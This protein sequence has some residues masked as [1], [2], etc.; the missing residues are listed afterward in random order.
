MQ[1]NIS[2]RKNW[3]FTLVGICT[4]FV[5]GCKPV[6]TTTNVNLGKE[7]YPILTGRTIEYFVD[8]TIYDDFTGTQISK[9]SYI[10]DVID[11]SFQDLTNNTVFYVKRYYKADTAKN[12]IF[13]QLYTVSALNSKIEVVQDNLRYIKL[14]F[15][16]TY[17]GTWGGNKYIN[18]NST[19]EV[20]SW[21]GDKPY[22]YRDLGKPYVD[23]ITVPMALS[24]FQVNELNGDTNRNNKQSFGE[25]TYGKE[26]YG[27]EI[28]LVFKEIANIKKD[29]A[30]GGKLKGFWTVM[31]C[32][33]WE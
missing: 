3:F 15:P 25:F 20:Y 16:V 9:K 32:V 18:T 10:K 12:Y 17:Q 26:I 2:N 30:F 31:K 24:V 27:K 13:Q 22:S 6:T 11:T 28:G 14:V 21:L 33:R 29:P 1:H 7:Y 23:S 4:A 5:F 19:S 8:S